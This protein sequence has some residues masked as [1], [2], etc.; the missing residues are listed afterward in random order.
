[1]ALTKVGKE[2][3]VGLDNSADATAINIS[4]GENVGIG[5]VPETT[6]NSNI[7]ALQLGLGAS[8]YGDNTATGL[9]ISANTVATLGS[10]LNG[11][12]YIG[13]DK[14]TTY[15]QYDGQHNFRVAS[16][17]SADGDIT[18]ST[19]LTIDNSGRAMIGTTTEGE[20]SA[21]DLTVAGSA[22]TG[23][24]IRAGTSNSSSI[25]MS[26]AT[27]GTGEYAGY[28]AYAHASDSMS[29][30][31]NAGSSMTID[32]TGAV[33]KPNQPAFQAKLDANQNN[34]TV[35]GSINTI[36][37]F[38]SEVFDQNADFNTSTYTFTAPV[39]GKYLLSYSLRFHNLDTAS[40]SV[41]IILTTSNRS[42]A[43]Y[44]DMA[45]FASDFDYF[46]FTTSLLVDM[47]ASDTASVK[48]Y[49]DGGAAQ[50]DISQYSNFT[51]VLLC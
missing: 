32:S 30:G 8:I 25:Y 47:D 36:I 49:I 16:S 10:S 23:I 39:T 3:V 38:D 45:G 34:L 46:Q 24:T 15:Q 6:W 5:V 22:N 7:D 13:S 50:N 44:Q 11:Y 37:E 19:A 48:Y 41:S 28:I 40:T 4:S 1:M 33:T 21:D 42:Y 27:S 18:W 51:G 43:N 26:D 12:K 31:T 9:Q 29:F 14:A 35:G 20:A 2:G 17:G